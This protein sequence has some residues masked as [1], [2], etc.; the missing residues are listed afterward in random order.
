MFAGFFI[1]S[2]RQSPARSSGDV[3][4]KRA[5][6]STYP[7]RKGDSATEYRGPA[8]ARA[9]TPTTK[10]MA[11]HDDIEAQVQRLQFQPGDTLV[12]STEKMLSMAQREAITA[13]LKQALSAVVPAPGVPVIVMD[14]GLRV[15]LISRPV[16]LGDVYA[17]PDGDTTPASMSMPPQAT[18]PAVPQSPPTVRLDRRC[19]CARFWNSYKSWRQYLGVL[20]SICAAWGVS[21]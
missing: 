11:M 7:R 6:S 10:G 1:C 12:V 8:C 21:R 15:S 18:D 19:W 9:V 13:S 5:Q 4:G 17:D 3:R 20:D 2:R 14:G 16:K